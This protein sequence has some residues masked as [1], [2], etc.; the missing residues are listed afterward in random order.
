MAITMVMYSP[1]KISTGRT[2]FTIA[3]FQFGRTSTS[4][5]I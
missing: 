1:S 2:L 5:I 3:S 4:E